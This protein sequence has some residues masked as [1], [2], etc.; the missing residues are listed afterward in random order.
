[1]QQPTPAPTSPP[2]SPGVPVQAPIDSSELPKNRNSPP[3]GVLA[4]LFETLAHEK[5]HEKRRKYLRVWFSRWREQVG[6]DLYPVIRLLLPHKDRERAV[7]G[8]KEKNLAR[9]YI[10]LLALDKKD[11]DASRLLNWKR[12]SE[13]HQTSGDFPSVFLD[14]ISRRSSLDEGTLTVEQLNSL[15]DDLALNVGNSE[16]QSRV[17]QRV[18]NDSTATEQSW[19]VRIILKD[20]NISV[21][22][23]TV[24][25]VF[26]PD[27][28]DLYNT[29]SDLK[30]VAWELWNPQHRLNADDKTIQLFRA[31]APMLCKRTTGRLEESVKAMEGRTFFIEEK[32]DGERMQLHKRGN[33]YFYCSRLKGKDYTYLY[34]KHVGAG[35][36]T[37]YISE[38]FDE[39]VDEIILDGE[40]LV[41]D[42]VSE[43]NLPFGTLKTAALDKSKTE[44]NPRPCFK[45]FDLLYLNGMS[46]LSKSVKFRKRNLKACVVE[47]K[48][49]IEFIDESEGKTAKDVRRRMDEIME[50][51]G[52]GLVLKHPDAE[53]I[54]NGRNKDW[55]KVKPEYMDNMGETLDLLVV[56]GKY[57]SGRRGGGVSSL[58]CAVLDD[59]TGSSEGS[60]SESR[61]SSF[62]RVGSGLTYADYV[63][64]RSRPWKRWDP[65]NPPSFL[66]TSPDRNGKED[67]G[68]LYLGPEDSFILEI[69][70]A[71]IVPSDQYHAGFTLRFPRVERIR[72][73][74]TV[75]DCMTTKALLDHISSRKKRKS[76]DA[77]GPES[78]LTCVV[79]SVS[80]QPTILSEFSRVNL[81]DVQVTDNIFEGM[82]FMVATDPKSRTRDDDKAELLRLI[83][84]NGGAFVQV[85]KKQQGLL[86]VY[87]GTST[88]YDIKLIMDKDVHDIVRPQWIID[89]IHAGRRLPLTKK[90]F[91]HATVL[92]Q[93]TSQYNEVSTMVEDSDTEPEDDHPA[94]TPAAK[95]SRASSELYKSE[96]VDISVKPEYHEWFQ[97]SGEPDQTESNEDDGSTTDP[98]SDNGNPDPGDEWSDSR[99]SQT[100]GDDSEWLVSVFGMN[101]GFEDERGVDM[102]EDRIAMAYDEEH[103]FRHLCFYLDSPS[104]ARKN[105]M[106]VSSEHECLME[107][108][109]AEV[110]KLVTV[111]G[112]RLG[113]LVDPKLTHVVLDKW[114][115][116]R[117]L[118]LMQR[119]SKPKRRHL[120]LSD[121]I[122]ACLDENT[123]LDETGQLYRKLG[124]FLACS[125]TPQ[126]LP[127][128]PFR[129]KPQYLA[130]GTER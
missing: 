123:L 18:Y 125:M 38:C 9:L 19:I 89:S 94:A 129:T 122:E 33:E 40:M 56:A 53:Y 78:L 36:L 4:K 72:Y 87:G 34:G 83:K 5:G 84:A 128:K 42:P 32:L 43:R 26:H 44:L 51:R 13:Q 117:R 113:D 103:I 39:R 92:R 59:R 100:L 95:S 46:L 22:E 17:M 119:T 75:G 97:A 37:P 63:Q 77:D 73:D 45:V 110:G 35:S 124:L 21:K 29:C 48:G 28:H 6:P 41:W 58:I 99:R 60:G 10:K 111:H 120:V 71:E 70:A 130:C 105:G 82:T 80:Y 68:E 65:A 114:D 96:P 79:L 16:V 106:V 1:M 85:A 104:N 11:P 64:I 90:Y 12:P 61:Y 127:H 7:Y 27:A 81:K 3:F 23:T 20:M 91:F 98:E 69:K 112:G 66:Q 54:L 102:G 116:S 62:C 2:G 57:G 118:E 8:L 126:I 107:Q 88:P 93:G 49:R 30:K 115:D 14:V 109:L 47:V 67:K 31:F 101:E 15:L 121:F 86:V 24:F 74:L 50:K 52:E 55:I 76:I 108:R 25:D